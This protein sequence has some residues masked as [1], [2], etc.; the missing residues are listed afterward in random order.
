MEWQRKGK[1]GRLPREDKREVALDQEGGSGRCL[2]AKA[3]FVDGL[4]LGASD[5]GNSF[6][7]GL[8]DSG[9]ADTLSC[10]PTSFNEVLG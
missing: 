3:N 9:C 6:D 5:T 2:I 7:D 8:M 10:A 1:G 4:S